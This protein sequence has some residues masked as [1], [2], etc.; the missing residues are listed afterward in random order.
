MTNIAYYFEVYKK[1][2][3]ENGGVNH[4]LCLC[5]YDDVVDKSASA[6]KRVM[7]I[8]MANLTTNL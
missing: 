1:R 6:V 3:R 7:F 2:R 4:T 5:L 8:C